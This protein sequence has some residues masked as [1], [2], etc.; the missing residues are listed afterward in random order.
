M[1]QVGFLW[2]GQ[3]NDYDAA[4]HNLAVSPAASSWQ[5]EMFRC[6]EQFLA[7]GKLLNYLPYRS[8]PRGPLVSSGEAKESARLQWL[9][10][11]NVILLR[12][13]TLGFFAA[14][15]VYRERRVTRVLFTY[16][17]GL[18]QRFA[19][20]AAR[21]L[22]ISWVAVIAEGNYCSRA[23]VNVF[24]SYS[25]FQSANLGP[26][27]KLWFPGGVTK[28]SKPADVSRAP[29]QEVVLTYAGGDSKWTGLLDLVS[30]FRSLQGEGFETFRLQIVGVRDVRR[31]TEI[32][33]GDPRVSVLGFLRPEELDSVMSQ[34]TAFVNPRPE[35]MTDGYKNFPSKILLYLRYQKPILST[36]S[37]GLGPMFDEALDFYSSE[38]EF[39][40]RLRELG[41]TT[42]SPTAKKEEH[43]AQLADSLAWESMAKRLFLELKAI[44]I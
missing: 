28:L 19:G 12:Q 13:I 6:V 4:M 14:L 39:S 33:D 11:L 7:P 43:L 1:R 36:R 25:Y 32:V 35:N 17:A 27:Q 21:L 26:N 16:N 40:Q 23:S 42:A 3:V 30:M 5:K 22:R 8:F 41:D 10:F 18:A 9:P 29:G 20:F 37:P 34:A 24:L 31:L 15:A 2:L 44:G 38:E